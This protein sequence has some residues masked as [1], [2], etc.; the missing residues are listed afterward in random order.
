MSVGVSIFEVNWG[1]N[2]CKIVAGLLQDCYKITQIQYICNI[3]SY[4]H[5]GYA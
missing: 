5:M 2:S 4:I 3:Y 1:L